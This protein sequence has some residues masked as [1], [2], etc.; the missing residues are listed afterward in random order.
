M[1]S[2]MLNKVLLVEDERDLRSLMALL[3]EKHDLGVVEAD[4]GPVPVERFQREG[5][6]SLAI[7][8]IN[9][10]GYSGVEVCRRLLAQDAD[11]PI[12]ICTAGVIHRHEEELRRL[13]VHRILSKPFYP[14]MLLEEVERALGVGA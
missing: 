7:I 8:D 4:D 1:S 2:P 3:L 6:F 5:P 10:P 9:L 11:L 14:E 13:G 12:I